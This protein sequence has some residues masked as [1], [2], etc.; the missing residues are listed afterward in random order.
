MTT[1]TANRSTDL[2]GSSLA[3]Q[4]EFLASRAEYPLS[5]HKQQ[6]CVLTVV[7]N[8]LDESKCLP[9]VRT[10]FYPANGTAKCNSPHWNPIHY[11]FKVQTL[12]QNFGSI[13]SNESGQ[14]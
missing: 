6:R 2:A 3:S 1:L 13:M 11:I 9:F 14:R 5:L 4:P 7:C 12:A 10:M 8:Q